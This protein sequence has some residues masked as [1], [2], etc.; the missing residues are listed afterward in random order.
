MCV[1]AKNNE[2][3]FLL[4][5][6]PERLL[7]LFLWFG[8]Y[9]KNVRY[10]NVRLR[11]FYVSHVRP[12]FFFSFFLGV[13]IHRLSH[14]SNNSNNT[15]SLCCWHHLF[16]IMTLISC[17]AYVFFRM[18]ERKCQCIYQCKQVNETINDRGGPEEC[19]TVF[20]RH[21]FNPL[22][23]HS[24]CTMRTTSHWIINSFKAHQNFPFTTESVS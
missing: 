1:H 6:E 3:S 21:I 2:S 22:I 11:N 8:K 20:G 7:W 14:V 24:V 23:C 18:S 10:K 19:A 5:I 17:V 13:C 15:V 16:R 12:T 4:K 9:M